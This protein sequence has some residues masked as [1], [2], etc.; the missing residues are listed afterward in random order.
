MQPSSDLMYLRRNGFEVL[1]SVRRAGETQ[2]KSKASELRQLF[3]DQGRGPQ[4]KGEAIMMVISRSPGPG[5][6]FVQT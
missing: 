2:T 1:H 5:H 4:V 6:I 3:I